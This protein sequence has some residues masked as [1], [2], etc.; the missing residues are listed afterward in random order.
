MKRSLGARTAAYPT[1][2][3]IVGTYSGQG[4]PNVMAV[5]WGG[6]C[7]SDPPCVAI[8]V[9]KATLTY[10]NLME[11]RAFTVSIP[12]V[13]HLEMADFFGIASGRDVDKLAAVGLTPVRSESTDAPYVEEFPVILEC[14]V[15]HVAELG[16]HTQFV[17]Q[18]LDVKV[19]ESCLD[20][21]GKPRM[22]L[23]RPFTWA[24]IENHYYATGERLGR[25]FTVG[26][27]FVADNA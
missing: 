19:E 18:I 15:V 20:A 24:P 7:C 5:A 10:G 3:F 6:I 4:D 1:P 27:G 11:R 2:V 22:S 9:R 16:L 8:S 17:G 26:K 25:G 21:D 14:K 23:I 12:S 13:D